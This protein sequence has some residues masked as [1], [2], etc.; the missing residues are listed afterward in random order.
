VALATSWFSA[1]QR[2]FKVESFVQ[3]IIHWSKLPQHC[4]LGLIDVTARRSESPGDVIWIS[5]FEY[6]RLKHLHRFWREGLVF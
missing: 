3:S 6:E 2:S 5:L 1:V 4:G